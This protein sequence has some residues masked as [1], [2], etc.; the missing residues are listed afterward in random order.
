MVTKL[1]LLC[2]STAVWG[3]RCL[4]HVTFIQ[5][6]QIELTHMR[7]GTIVHYDFMI[8]GRRLSGRAAWMGNTSLIVI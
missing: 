4:V 3:A 8:K 7:I 5:S 6:G 2:L 1:Q